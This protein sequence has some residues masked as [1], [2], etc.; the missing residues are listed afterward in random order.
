M[1]GTGIPQVKL[2]YSLR[3]LKL[4]GTIS[5][6]NVADDFIALVPVEVQTARQKTVHWLATGSEP[7]PFAIPV[8]TALAKAVLLPS[9]CLMTTS[10]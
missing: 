9:D 10:R 2:T 4:V 7:V 3:G 6:R 5:Q 8:K 1:Y